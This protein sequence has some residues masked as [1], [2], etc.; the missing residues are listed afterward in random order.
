VCCHDHVIRELVE[1]SS[2]FDPW[3]NQLAVGLLPPE[4]TH[5]LFRAFTMD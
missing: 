2:A 5:P 3:R 4:R 1:G